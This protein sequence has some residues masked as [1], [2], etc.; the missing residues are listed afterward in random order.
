VLAHFY[1][2]HK[3]SNLFRGYQALHDIVKWEEWAVDG[4]CSDT[5]EHNDIPDDP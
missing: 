4:S 1:S 5:E 2:N 3:F